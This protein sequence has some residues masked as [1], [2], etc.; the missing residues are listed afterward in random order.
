MSGRAVSRVLESALEPEVKFTAAVLSSFGTDDGDRI[1]PSV[2]EVAYLRG[3]SERTV[4]VHLKEL[5]QMA[6]L[7]VVKAATQWWPV[8]Y[9][10]RLDLLPARA[11][12]RP[13]DRQPYLLGPPGVNCASPLPGVKSSVPGVKPTSPDPSLDP[14]LRTHRSRAREAEPAGVKPTAPLASEGTL[15]MVRAVPPDRD[16]GAHAWCGRICVPKFLHRQFKQALGGPV[17]KRAT[18]LRMFYAACLDA[19]SPSAAIDPDPVR[20]WRAAFTARF[21]Q[22]RPPAMRYEGT[23]S[24][25]TI[26][27]HDPLCM[28]RHA[29]IE[30]TLADAR[31]AR[32][33][34]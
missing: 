16:H 2:G 31:A 9:R 28:S 5:R 21:S 8:H 22:P 27:T 7:E 29:C 12:Y 3:V 11:P 15:P 10:M 14:S 32:E 13:P 18:R 30:R 17:T 33:T 26:C 25:A 24:H 20:F 1:W 6:I 4:Q 23:G 19:L 34:A